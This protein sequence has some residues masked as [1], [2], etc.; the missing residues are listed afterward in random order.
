MNKSSVGVAGLRRIDLARAS[1]CNIET[2]RYYENI[3]V[4]PA[5]PRSANGYRCYD[6]S[7]LSRLGFVMRARQ[8]GFSLDEVRELLRLVDQG[9]NTCAEAQTVAER[10]LESVR[11]RISDL[12]RVER[13]LS[14]T[15]SQCTGE[16]VPGCAVIDALEQKASWSR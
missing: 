10:H 8:L 7:H 6:A 1:G 5:P 2:I 13:V 3:G 9:M 16:N 4:M 15:V 14:E 12:K 11:A